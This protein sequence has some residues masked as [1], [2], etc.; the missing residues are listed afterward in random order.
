MDKVLNLDHQAR[1]IIKPDGKITFVKNALPGEIIEYKIIK[2]TKK[3]NLGQL[4][5]IIQKSPHRV[6]SMCPYFPKCGGCSLHH[7][8]YLDTLDY[9]KEKV[10]DILL[11]YA[12][13]KPK[14]N[15]IANP[16]YLNYRNKITLQIKGKKIGYF[17]ENTHD[18][19]E[20]TNCLVAKDSINAIIPDLKKLNINSGSI[21]I[22]S[23][24]NDEIMLIINTSQKLELDFKELSSKHK[25]VGV[26][27][28]NKLIYN[29]DKFIENINGKLFQVSYNSFFQVNNY[30]N[31]KLFEFIASNVTK[32]VIVDMFCGVG[33]LGIIAS[34]KAK[35]VYGIENNYHAILNALVNKKMNKRSNIE[36]LLGDANDL[37][38]KIK[39]NIDTII[40]D[41]PRAGLSQKGINAILNIKPQEIIYISCD[42]M[43]LARDLKRLKNIYN[44]TQVHIV[45]MFSFSYH[46]ES[47]CV[48]KKQ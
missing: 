42:A 48:L 36:F 9:K 32:K 17:A 21:T 44:I 2:E 22:R 28:N 41:P 7:M 35:K 25:L 47:I 16:I 45:D 37:I 13:I 39:D 10:Q 1:G 43:S 46:V 5:N 33:T 40:I 20:I 29:E 4:T 11:R 23:N 14:I 3:Y 8:A 15:V 6:A 34:F 24:Y 38:S 18:I 31:E 26:I 12:N 30:I 27:L 19:I